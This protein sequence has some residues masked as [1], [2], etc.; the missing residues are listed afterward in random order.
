M[1]TMILSVLAGLFVPLAFAQINETPRISTQAL[2]QVVA[3]RRAM[4]LDI[5][6]PADFKSGHI[7]GAIDFPVTKHDLAAYLPPNPDKL[8]VIYCHHE[9]CPDYTAAVAAA[10]D[11]GYTNV[12][13]YE[14]GLAGWKRA[15]GQV[16]RGG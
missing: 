14:P 12:K 6:G 1:K 15:G 4:L 9:A 3:S 10:T 5:S 7:P 13:L 16:Q 2:R 8:I 11:L